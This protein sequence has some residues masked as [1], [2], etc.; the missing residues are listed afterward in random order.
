CACGQG[1]LSRVARTPSKRGRN[2]ARFV[3][4]PGP[5]RAPR[6]AAARRAAPHAQL[7]VLLVREG[8]RHLG[9]RPDG[10]GQ[11]AAHLAHGDGGADVRGADLHLL[12]RLALADEQPAAPGPLAAR[13]GAVHEGGRQVPRLGLVDPLLGALR[14]ALEDDGELQGRAHRTQD[15]RPFR[16]S[17]R[18]PHGANG[19]QPTPPPFQRSAA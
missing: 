6:E 16:R 8:G 11:V 5:G 4:G 15:P 1:S 18:G 14:R 9:G 17:S 10:E 7:Q 12:P 13:H 19:E 2:R 3:A